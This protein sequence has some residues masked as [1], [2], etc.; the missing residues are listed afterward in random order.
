M[1]DIIK[2]VS[3]KNQLINIFLKHMKRNIL[4]I[5]YE[6]ETNTIILQIVMEEQ[7]FLDKSYMEMID[8]ELKD[9]IV[10]VNTI[11]VSKD[12]FNKNKGNW[13]PMGYKWLSHVL[14]SKNEIL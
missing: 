11:Y 2:Y 13:A 14:Y 7:S 1:K 12:E 4:D 3:L 8:K 9:Y 6:Y 5:S 10:N